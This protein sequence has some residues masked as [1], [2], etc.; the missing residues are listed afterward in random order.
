M[1]E[2]IIDVLSYNSFLFTLIVVGS[3]IALMLI[4]KLIHG[5]FGIKKIYT[6]KKDMKELSK[7]EKLY[8]KKE[9]NSIYLGTN[10]NKKDIFLKDNAK[11]IYVCGTTGSGK[12]VTLSN[13]IKYAVEKD[14]PV[15]IV[16]GKGDT[17]QNS[18]LDIVKKFKKDKKV[19]VIDL[20]N[21]KTSDKYNPFNGTSYTV[22]KDM[23][24]NMTE[25]SEEHYKYNVELYLQKL[26][27]LLIKNDIKL[28]F[29]TITQNM[30]VES[31]QVL[32]NNLLEKGL[33]TKREHI[34]DL[35]FV[36]ATATII[37][38][39]SAR[40]STIIESELG[41]IFSDD[42]IDIYSALKEN[43]IILFV[44]NPL[45][46]P[47]LSTLIGR[48]ITI[49]SK[50]AISNLYQDKIDRGFFLFDEINVYASRSL[51]DLVN[52]S[53]SA[54]IT[55]ILA[56]QSLSD[57]EESAGEYFKE[58]VIENCNNYIIMR[59]NSAINAESWANIIGTKETMD[60]TYQIKPEGDTGSGS[61]RRVREFLYHP[62][63]I[64]NLPVGT[65]FLISKDNNFKT[66]II[67]NKPFKGD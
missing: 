64:K 57:L 46:Y 66:K 9:D 4:I 53:R 63:E 51:L 16:D 44:L 15:L 17:N 39:A 11:H 49:D 38:G 13:F 67:I 10:P 12:T 24:I 55:C 50:K 5:D 22:V 31:F 32:S 42:G 26:V 25:W 19:Y 45:I 30:N 65:G 47:E 37:I 41:E 28:S 35:E 56:S 58:Q 52:K 2:T 23:L 59:Q 34:I 40:F 14:S 27:E 1:E 8:M 18:L 33:I 61:A 48:L 54:N 3:L 21:P 60:V 43:A 20:N 7:K 62:D 6:F 36:K 29:K